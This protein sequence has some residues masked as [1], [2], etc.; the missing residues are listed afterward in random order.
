M[1]VQCSCIKQLQQQERIWFLCSSFPREYRTHSVWG[2]REQGNLQRY[3]GNMDVS[4]AARFVTFMLIHNAWDSK[5]PLYFIYWI[6]L[7][8]FSCAAVELETTLNSFST[9]EYLISC[10]K[11]PICLP[12]S[13]HHSLSGVYFIIY[14]ILFISTYTPESEWWLEIGRLIGTFLQ[15]LTQRSHFFTTST[16]FIFDLRIDPT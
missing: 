12:V 4:T 16:Y 15:W 1:P 6:L 9:S 8:G 5:Y 2:L 10:W 7:G 3:K 11:V 13:S 14:K